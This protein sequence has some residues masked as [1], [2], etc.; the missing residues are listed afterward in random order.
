MY[1]NLTNLLPP[2]RRHKLHREYVMRLVTVGA[3]FLSL[4]I[5]VSGLLLVPSYRS[6][7]SMAVQKQAALTALGGP[8]KVVSQNENDS[9]EFVNTV[10]YLGGLGKTVAASAA[11]RVVILIPREGVTLSSITFSAPST[12]GVVKTPAK[13]TITGTAATREALRAYDLAL[14]AA[15]FISNVD[16]PISA[17]AKESNIAFTITLTGSLKP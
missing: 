6:L 16:L 14:S 12:A 10:S 2:E 11:V 4:L 13:M 15:P 7:Q 1:H 9:A 5:V 8:A 3:L 17:Y